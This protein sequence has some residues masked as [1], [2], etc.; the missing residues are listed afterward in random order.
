[1]EL[2]HFWEI[3][4]SLWLEVGRWA[5]D[6][7]GIRSAFSSDSWVSY[8]SINQSLLSLLV[9]IFFYLQPLFVYQVNVVNRE[10]DV[11]IG[12][13]DVLSVYLH[14]CAQRQTVDNLVVLCMIA[15]SRVITN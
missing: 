8:Q 12:F 9:L 13:L 11:F 14:A 1:M 15:Y 6:V 10:D 2:C 3:A 4:F 5:S 7:G